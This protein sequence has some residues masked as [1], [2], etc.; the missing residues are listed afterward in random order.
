MNQRL[1]VHHERRLIGELSQGEAT[2][3]QFRYD[4]SWLSSVGAFPISLSLPLDGRFAVATG[5]RFFA[6][7][8]PEGD[9]RQRIGEALGISQGNDFE[10]LKAIGGDCAGALTITVSRALGP[11]QSPARYEPVTEEQL[12]RWSIGKPD[13]FSAVSGQCEVRLSLAGAQDKLPVHVEGDRI[14]IPVADSPSTHLLKFASPY[15][16]HLPE[17]ETFVSLLA[18]AVGL[19][20][21]DISLRRT[22]RARVAVITRYDRSVQGGYLRRLHQEDFCQALGISPANKYEKEG[23]PSLKQCAELIRRHTSFPLLELQKLLQWT[24]FNL[25]VGNADAHGKNLSLLYGE[26]GPP[27]LAPFYDLVCTRNYP[28]ISRHLAM[29]IGGVSNPDQVGKRQLQALAAD[30][31]MR[32]NAV[33]RAATSLVEQLPEAIAETTQSFADRFGDSPVIRRLP[34]IIRKQIRRLSS[35]LNSD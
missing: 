18:G 10:L 6:N 27:S 12:A 9:V 22:V 33:I 24:L 14:Q 5:H 29:S 35:Q 4:P 32:P 17:N 2:P 28:K 7:L 26:D 23:G 11:V 30:L 25:V 21:V 8:L 13:A 1:F 31:Q 34:I 16:S 19:P 15:H 20:V 3:L